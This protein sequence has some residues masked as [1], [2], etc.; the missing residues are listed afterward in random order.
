MS[1]NLLYTHY[2]KTKEVHM[3]FNNK[4]PQHQ[5]A[6]NY[7]F[8]RDFVQSPSWKSA[9]LKASFMSALVISLGILLPFFLGFFM[10]LKQEPSHH[11][12]QYYIFVTVMSIIVC[13]PL[14]VFFIRLGIQMYAKILKKNIR[15]FG[16]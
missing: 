6:G 16:Y 12:F 1:H 4:K 5:L 8:Y 15:K 10:S 7:L 13:L 9:R 3:I 2:I 14:S 11:F